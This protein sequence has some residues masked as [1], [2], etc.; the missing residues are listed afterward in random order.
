MSDT[1]ISKVILPA[2]P[3]KRPNYIIVLSDLL[4][5]PNPILKK[6]V[7]TENI[8][9]I[10]KGLFISFGTRDEIRECLNLFPYI[11]FRRVRNV[12]RVRDTISDTVQNRIYD[13]VAYH[14][15]SP[16]HQQKKQAQRLVAKSL[17]I[18]LRPGVFLFPHLRMKERR[19]HYELVKN[20]PM[21]DSRAF[22]NQ[23]VLLGA[24]V[25]RWTRLKLVG[26]TSEYLVDEVIQKMMTKE[27]E[28]VQARSR[29][30]RDLA[31]DFDVPVERLK[32]KYLVLMAFYRVL[33]AR[34][35][36]IQ[37]I[38]GKDIHCILRKTYDQLLS[39]R[40]AIAARMV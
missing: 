37:R 38:W 20:R 11:I 35:R 18:R 16:T 10:S 5:N 7:H 36:L 31:K 22:E 12:P 40:R 29:Y 39:A 3:S 28:K 26:L 9:K 33:K 15:K 1:V 34:Y 19:K 32:E 4:G 30:L 24:N 14:F 2:D 6:S 13:L 23:M 25:T 17:S 27:L 8:C 21:L